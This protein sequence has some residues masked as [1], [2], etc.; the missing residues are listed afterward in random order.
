MKKQNYNLFTGLDKT[1]ILKDS[2]TVEYKK[3]DIILRENDICSSVAIINSG[4]VS[5]IQY[6][7]DGRYNI[8]RILNENDVIGLNLI[9]SSNPIYK[10]NFICN[11]KT[12]ITYIKKEILL[13]LMQSNPILLNNILTLISNSAVVLNDQIKLLSFK[14]I[15]SKLCYFLYNEYKKNGPTFK[16]K[17]TKTELAAL[18][19]VERPSLSYELSK[20]IKENIISNTNKEYT[21]L[22]INKINQS[23]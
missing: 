1:N 19:N 4:S 8:I 21:I 18:L 14:T 5:A 3:D 22:D 17:Y 13:N 16:I 12:N 7:S 6:F 2:T 20:L 23:I 10:A 9:F 15:R 11:T